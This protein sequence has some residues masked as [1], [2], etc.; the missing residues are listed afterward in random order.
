M[1]A[2]RIHAAD[3][4]Y[5]AISA[6]RLNWGFVARRNTNHCLARPALLPAPVNPI[7]EERKNLKQANRSNRFRK[8]FVA[9]GLAVFG[10]WQL[11]AQQT[12]I[13]GRVTDPTNASIVAAVVSATGEDGAKASTLTNVQ[14][15][16]QFPALRGQRYVL[17]VESPGFTPAERTLTLAVGQIA[18]VDVGLQVAAASSSVAVEAT[19]EGVNTMSSTVA[20]DVSPT[21]VSKLPLN[22]RNYLQ[23]ATMVPG[24]TS[25]DVTYSPLGSTDAGKIQINVDGQQ[26][27]QTTSSSSFG[28]PQ[29]SQDAID[30]FQIITNR[31]DATLGRSARVQ[32]NVQ[33]KSGSNHFRGTLYGY[34][35]NDAFNASDSVAHRVLPFSDQQ[36]GGTIGGP[37][38]KDKLFFFFA[39]EGERQPNTSITTPTGFGG[40]TYSF[41]NQLTTGSYLLHNDWQVNGANRISVRASRYTLGIPFNNVTG[42]AS[43]TRATN[44]TKTSYAVLGTLSSTISGSLVNDLKIGYNHFDYS[45]TPLILS[46]EFRLPTI[47]VGSPYN[48]PQ[49][50]G[51]NI[52]QFR[53]DLFWLKGSHS[54]KI[55]VDYLHAVYAGNFGQNVRGTVLG[56][57]SGVSALNLAAI[58]PVYNDPSTWN[59]AALSPYATSYTQGFGNFNFSIPTNAIGAF[60]Q[61]D[62]KISP[63]LTVNLGI[64]Y[65]NDLGIFNPDLH[66]KSGIQTPHYN[67]NLLF[68]PRIGFAWDVTG[69]RKTVIRGGAGIFYADIQANQTYDDTLFN[70]ETTISPAVQATAANPINLLAPFG[71]VTGAQFLS[72]AVPISAQ[73][74]QPLAPN[75][76]TPYSLQMS[77]GV[78]RQLSK[79]WVVSADY[80][81]FRVY[82]DW[83]RTDANLYYNP[84]TGYA[85]NPSLGR[86]NPNFVGILNFTTPDAAGSIN[87]ALQVS[88][89][90][91]FSQSFSASAAYTLARLKDSTTGAFYYPNNQYDLAAEWANSPDNQLH[92]L[93]IAGAYQWK[94]GLSL[95]GSFHYGSGQ[96]FATTANQ[97][98]FGLSGVTDRLFTASS[99]YYTPPS[100]ITQLTL[101]GVA[102]DLVKRDSL[103]GN[104]ID[105]VDLRLSKTFTV[106]E[107][108]RFIPIVEAF[109]LFNHSNFGAY[110]TSINVSSYGTP[111][112]N[113]DL[114]YAARML[115][116]AG[117]FEF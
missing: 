23:L 42:N 108:I 36:F 14:G 9:M 53:D 99:A 90:H 73:T 67:D 1:K 86:P 89:Q 101:G 22:G 82:H 3:D 52:E 26:M 49:H 109:N 35:R 38:L 58:F 32:V 27:T 103:V 5:T 37:I 65:D 104:S 41:D 60:V 94:Y 91:R 55:G 56:F 107:H 16:Y 13:S 69:S 111:V 81:H 105:R 18:T 96:N 20:G 31:F 34:F 106:K 85:K 39:Y 63:K 54:F 2:V 70:G 88:V 61:D 64:R 75:V 95:S 59:I 24:I 78:E 50:I 45:N 28:Q 12:G 25:N 79:N 21:E 68:Q 92:T 40:L 114:A 80:V 113:A 19:A 84:A 30:Q 93:T 98:P 10:C 102:Y 44:S 117:R 76:H 97:N 100:N 57:S 29:Y 47:T 7:C 33:T 87:D 66:L 6:L 46:P 17:R 116:F 115:Q 77:L 83:I 62:W 51:Q 8:T 110:Q 43:P 74:I 48:Y 15:L 4:L 72:G 112:Q 71:N 11:S